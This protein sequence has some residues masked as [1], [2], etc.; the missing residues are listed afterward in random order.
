MLEKKFLADYTFEEAL[1][2][3]LARVDLTTERGQD[4]RLLTNQISVLHW[5]L[6]CQFRDYKDSI[7]RMHISEQ[8]AWRW[9]RFFYNTQKGKN[10]K[11]A[12]FLGTFKAVDAGHVPWDQPRHTP[13]ENEQL[14]L[15]QT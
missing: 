6:K 2:A 4:V 8:L 11:W 3:I 14:T 1:D 7:E 13:P 15:E 10:I 12:E 9:M 5:N